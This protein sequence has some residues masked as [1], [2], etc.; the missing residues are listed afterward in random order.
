MTAGR[1]PIHTGIRRDV[2]CRPGAQ[3]HST[4]TLGEVCGCLGQTLLCRANQ[5]HFFIPDGASSLP[6]STT[7]YGNT[8]IQDHDPRQVSLNLF[9]H[10]QNRNT[11]YLNRLLKVAKIIHKKTLS[12][13]L[14]KQQ[15]L[16][17]RWLQDYD[18]TLVV[19]II[20]AVLTISSFF[21]VR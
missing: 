16:D 7:C 5:I 15:V 12:I 2:L 1:L 9:P 14:G 4:R 18:L 10:Q 6:P 13:L 8:W 11:L 3:K 19:T 17:K 21:A 20:K